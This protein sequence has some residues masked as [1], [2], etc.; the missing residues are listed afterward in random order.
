VAFAKLPCGTGG[1]EK[2]I[3]Q[4]PPQAHIAAFADLLDKIEFKNCRTN[5]GYLKALGMNPPH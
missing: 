2:R 3:A 5:D 4:R 1:A